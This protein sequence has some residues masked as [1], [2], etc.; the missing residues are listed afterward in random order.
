MWQWFFPLILLS[1]GKNT[2]GCQFFIT[3]KATPWLDGH[4][5]VFGKVLEGMDVIYKIGETDTN[6][7]DAPLDTVA[8]EKST[9]AK[10]D[11]SLYVAL[12]S[13]DS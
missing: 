8:I 10:A 5:T 1:S 3:L 11:E 6:T 2:N 4:H 9:V 13:A 12:D 7:V